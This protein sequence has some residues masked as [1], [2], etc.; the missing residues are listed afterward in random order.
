MQE[1]KVCELRPES[2]AGLSASNAML[3][4]LGNE[5]SLDYK[6]M[7]LMEQDFLHTARA[8]FLVHEAELHATSTHY[9][10]Y[11]KNLFGNKGE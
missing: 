5:G 1:G 7:R 3:K 10:D 6:L 4:K 11:S 9:A 8:F 2:S